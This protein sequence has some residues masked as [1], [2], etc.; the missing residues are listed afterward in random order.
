[1]D[2]VRLAFV[3]DRKISAIKSL[4]CVTRGG[5][6]EAKDMI[7]GGVF[8]CTASQRLRMMAAYFD[9][10]ARRDA[11]PY[12]LLDDWEEGNGSVPSIVG[13]SHVSLWAVEQI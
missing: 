4:R 1:M 8:E 5:L 13:V 3:G 10:E 6:K 2:K 7:E 12:L 11:N 9:Y